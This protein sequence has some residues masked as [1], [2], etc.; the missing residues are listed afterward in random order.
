[1]P[2]RNESKRTRGLDRSKFEGRAREL[3]AKAAGSVLLWLRRDPL[4]GSQRQHGDK[5]V[6]R[7]LVRPSS[8][9]R[10]IGGPR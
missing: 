6:R 4:A 2:G 8:P 3:R 1:L 10:E 9:R 7:Q 5:G